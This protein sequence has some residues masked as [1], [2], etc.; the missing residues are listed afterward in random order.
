MAAIGILFRPSNQEAKAAG[1]EEAY[2]G[3]HLCDKDGKPT[4]A[5]KQAEAAAS[6]TTTSSGGQIP[7]GA[8]NDGGPYFAQNDP[9][10]ANQEYAKAKDPDF[11]PDWCGT[12]IAQCGCAMTSV[13]TV[14]ALYDILQMPDGSDLTPKSVNDWFNG[15]ARKTTRG[16]VS[17]GYI[18]GDVIWTAANQFSGEIAKI[19]PGSPTIKFS[20]TGTGSEGR[21]SH[22]T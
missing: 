12:T 22:G 13:T 18:Y 4:D 17:Q 10:W 9:Q 6:A 11:G 20:R 3:V 15:N 5:V 2:A 16:W 8:N 7:K 19:R 21:N 1:T 14:M